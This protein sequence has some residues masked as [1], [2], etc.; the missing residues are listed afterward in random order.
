MRRHTIFSRIEI[1]TLVEAP[2]CL[3]KPLALGLGMNPGGSPISLGDEDMQMPGS[4]AGN[5][6]GVRISMSQ[7]TSERE[8]NGSG[9]VILAESELHR[10]LSSERRRIL[11]NVL[12]ER[13]A[14]MDLMELAWAIS[15]RENGAGS[16]PTADV[17]QVVI[18]LHHH[19]LPVLSEA[20]IVEYQPA[21][22]KIE[23]FSGLVR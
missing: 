23:T 10:L 14:P 13:P 20:G 11:L 17:E 22:K 6:R 16:E 8:I 3:Q 1:V 5:P 2:A 19:H 15:K 18:T 12:E 21:S 9:K 4:L 7:S